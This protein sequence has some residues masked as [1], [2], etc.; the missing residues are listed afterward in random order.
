MATNTGNGFRRGSVDNR[1]QTYN[2]KNDTWSKHDADTGKIMD[3]KSS[4]PFKGVAKHVD[5]RRK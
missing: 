2:P 1:F 4:N 3:T 5:D